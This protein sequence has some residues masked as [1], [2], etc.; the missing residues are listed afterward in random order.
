MR[1]SNDLICNGLCLSFLLVKINTI[2][3]AF[4]R[5]L[6]WQDPLYKTFL[7]ISILR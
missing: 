2:L 7:I 3:A 6:K 5:C 1:C 4:N